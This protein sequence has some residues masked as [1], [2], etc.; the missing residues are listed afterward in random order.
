MLE[1][2]DLVVFDE[3]D[4]VQKTL[5][6]FFTPSTEFTSFMNES[7]Q[8]CAD[9]MKKGTEQLDSM[10]VNARNYSELRL[11]SF[12]KLCRVKEMIEAFP[13][14][15]AWNRILQ[16]TFSAMTLFRQLREDSENQKHPLPDRVL[17]LL[18]TAMDEPEDNELSVIL[19]YAI[20]RKHD[21]KCD[22]YL[23][24]WLKHLQ[25]ATDEF[26][27][28]HIKLYLIITQFDK[29]I[30]SL[31]DA[32]SFLTEDEKNDM[33]LFNFLQARFTAQ[34]KLLPSS[35]MGNLFGLRYFALVSSGKE[36]GI[37]VMLIYL[38]CDSSNQR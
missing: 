15:D 10:G 37:S 30:Q 32:Y 34:Q 23:R 22:S 20:E 35:A 5:D 36:S 28:R 7:A 16:D 19:D 29:Y 38:P 18:E 26:I 33:E 4:K 21:E 11:E 3:C 1:Q 17:D 31:E 25:C 12:G 2:A 14:Q 8:D 6:E 27:I 24:K 13:K 9:D